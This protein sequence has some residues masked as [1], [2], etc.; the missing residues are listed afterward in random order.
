MKHYYGISEFR[1]LHSPYQLDLF[2]YDTLDT[3][4]Q[5]APPQIHTDGMSPVAMQSHHLFT[6]L[7]GVTLGMPGDF[8]HTKDGGTI[9]LFK[10]VILIDRYF[11]MDL[12]KH[13]FDAL[14]IREEVLY[15]HITHTGDAE[16]ALR[17]AE[18]YLTH[19]T[20]TCKRGVS[21]R[22]L[23]RAIRKSKNFECNLMQR[24]FKMDRFDRILLRLL[25]KIQGFSVHNRIRNRNLR[26]LHRK[27]PVDASVE[28]V[29]HLNRRSAR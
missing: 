6:S 4:Y 29:V 27:T 15:N 25:Y 18:Y 3:I 8:L 24:V 13:E 1:L 26:Q 14:A 19:D 11:Y 28:R 5:N 12:T 20:L 16:I 22:V 2:F 17:P 21:A 7:R 10:H 23:R 9:T